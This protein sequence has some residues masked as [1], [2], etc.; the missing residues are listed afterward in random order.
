M[1]LTRHAPIIA[2]RVS[3]NLARSST[4]QDWRFHGYWQWPTLVYHSKSHHCKE[5]PLNQSIWTHSSN[6]S[7]LSWW[8]AC[9]QF[10]RQRW[11][12]PLALF[13]HFQEHRNFP[14][15]SYHNRMPQ[16]C[17]A[18]WPCLKVA[19]FLSRL[20]SLKEGQLTLFSIRSP[21]Q[22]I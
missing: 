5:P 21:F 3:I 17:A 2:L 18:P 13:V 11:T 19:M 10:I 14:F 8:K 12:S 1:K 15:R 6:P 22:L 4:L 20:V 7:Q 16:A 9:P